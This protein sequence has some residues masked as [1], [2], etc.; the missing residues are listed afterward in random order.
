MATVT[1]GFPFYIYIHQKHNKYEH[2]NILPQRSLKIKFALIFILMQ[3]FEMD[4]AGMVT[5]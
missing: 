5:S 1:A 4:K 2:K 3:L